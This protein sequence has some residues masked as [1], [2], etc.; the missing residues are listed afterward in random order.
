MIKYILLTLNPSQSD[1][2]QRHG[3]FITMINTFFFFYKI[4]KWRQHE[5]DPLESKCRKNSNNY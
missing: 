4:K 3:I 2:V 1:I 5:R